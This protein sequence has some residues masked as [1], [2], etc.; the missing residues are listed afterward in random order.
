MRLSPV[1]A[2]ALRTGTRFLIVGGVSTVIEITVLNLLVALQWDIV[3]AKIVAS[4]IALVNAYFGNREWTFRRRGRRGRT[5]EVSLFIA[6]NVACT[7]LGAVL[8]WAGVVLIGSPG[9]TVSTLV[10]NVI[11]LASIVIVVLAR[12]AAYHWIFQGN[13]APAATGA[14]ATDSLD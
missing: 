6:A 7:A 10:L 4:L 3:T 1:L 2:R 13:K 11:N 12:P 8:V 14:G 5:T 9:G